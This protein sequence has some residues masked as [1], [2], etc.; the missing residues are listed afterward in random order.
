MWV[1]S[2]P[3]RCCHQMLMS[4]CSY[5]QTSLSEQHALHHEATQILVV[6]S[7]WMP[8]GFW[9]YCGLPSFIRR[10]LS[11]T[12]IVANWPKLWGLGANT[13][14]NSCCM[15]LQSELEQPLFDPVIIYQAQCAM[16]SVFRGSWST[17]LCVLLLPARKCQ[18]WLKPAVPGFYLK[19][20]EAVWRG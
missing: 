12:D 8:H 17:V 15:H 7:V 18:R 6:N 19:R 13:R 3:K 16:H 5:G 2:I 9:S 11:G 20:K 1:T 14:G 4:D 10:L